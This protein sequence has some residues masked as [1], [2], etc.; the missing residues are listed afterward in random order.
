[1]ID[2]DDGLSTETRADGSSPIQTPEIA[3]RCTDAG[4]IAIFAY[5]SPLRADRVAVRE[6]VGADRFVEVHVATSLEKCRQR[7]AR[8]AYDPKRPA[9]SYEPPESPELSVSLDELDPEDAAGLILRALEKRGLL[10]ST[11]AL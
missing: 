4:M 3:R 9:P 6:R 1:M 10:P 8:G 2:P 11:Y 5:G 7:D